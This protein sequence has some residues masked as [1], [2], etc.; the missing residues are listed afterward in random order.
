MYMSRP[1]PEA[2][3]GSGGTKMLR[4]SGCFVTLPIREKFA[5]PL[6]SNDSGVE[7]PQ[8]GHGHCPTGVVSAERRHLAV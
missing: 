4:W 2:M 7:T 6:S 8:H 1:D 3:L 5:R